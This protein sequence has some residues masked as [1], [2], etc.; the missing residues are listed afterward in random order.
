MSPIARMFACAWIA[1]SVIT[2]AHAGEPDVF[3][4]PTPQEREQFRK[5]HLR[6]SGMGAPLS[7]AQ[8]ALAAAQ[9]D[10]DILHYFL[11]LEFIPSTQRVAGAVGITGK[12]LVNGFQHVVLDLMDNMT[13]T[14]VLR[15][16]TS[17]AFTHTG[18]LLDV[19]LDQTFGPGQTFVVQV[20]YNGVPNPTGF[21]SIGWT[22]GS[23]GAAGSMVWTLS[24]PDGA[25]TWWPCKDRPDDKATVEEWWTVPNTWTAT[26]N[27][28]LTGTV[29]VSGNRTQYKWTMHD[30]VTTYLVSVAATAYS[31]FSQTYTTLAGGTMPIDHYVYPEHL[32]KAQT[33]FAP[34][35]SMIAYYAQRFGE[36]PFVEDKYGMSEFA[37]GGGMEHSTNT[38]YG[39]QLVNGGH[40]YDYIMAH[41]LSHQW[42]GDSVSPKT[43]AD[44][45]LNEG[46]ATYSE[47]L[48]AEHLGGA[49]G[50]RNYMNSF[51]RSSFSGSVYNPLDLFGATVYDKG[52]WV[53]HMLRHVVG[54]TAFFN[55]LRD[56]YADRVDGTGNTAEYQ[57]THEARYGATLDFFFQEWVY[58]TG[59]PRY[60]YGWTT[61]NLGSGTYRSYVRIH[62]T[63]TTSG[64]FTMPIDLTLVTA[65]G[66]EV[67]T[68]ANN[69]LDQDFT[70][71]TTAPLTDLRVDDQDWILKEST[72]TIQLA[73]AD[74][75]GVP[76]R[77]DNCPADA[78]PTQLDFD[79]DGTGDVCDPDDDG[80]G[81]AD[82]DDCAPLDPAQG[83]VGLV[84]LVTIDRSDGA[85]HLSWSP[86]AR[87]ETHDVQRGSLT[88]LRSGSYGACLA[89]LLAATTYDDPETPPENDGFFYVVRGH[90]AGC[91]G[92]GSFG[93]DSSG[94]TR[95]PACP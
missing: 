94:A 45:W 79:H 70:L 20:F 52:G 19:T 34:L 35:P 62:Q 12:S 32:S 91:G 68:V 1:G 65:S 69:Q 88:A 39:W 59:Q 29:A 83:M 66:T 67:R 31:K 48:W 6:L 9:D 13:V 18:N 21:D 53:Q 30:P 95:P 43:W 51:W 42:W 46:F 89:S 93:A 49:T 86:A 24:E 60:E 56:W 55:G 38:S 16:T 22:K 58:G 75:D 82:V 14:Q 47:A 15:G 81:L 7:P 78:N 84:S 64:M 41:E 27:G 73:D 17:L 37:W 8:A 23:S 36:Y 3:P 57:A 2:A 71:D 33:S 80:D 85:A 61:A 74:L 25:K 44:V 76:D 26:G 92:G 40:N 50:Y 90:D 77:N 4:V 11:Q 54:D 10:V 63:Q 72:T 28:L 87:A 5:Q